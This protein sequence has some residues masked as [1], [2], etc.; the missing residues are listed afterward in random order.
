[1]LAYKFNKG[2]TSIYFTY[3]HNSNTYIR[4]DKNWGYGHSMVI[5]DEK[6]LFK[7]VVHENNL[8]QPQMRKMN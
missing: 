5:P 3:M 7:T 4:S 1:M 2:N 6:C 8:F